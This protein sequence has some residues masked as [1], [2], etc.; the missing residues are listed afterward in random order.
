MVNCI[1]LSFYSHVS[2]LLFY[3][4]VDLRWLKIITMQLANSVS[5][6]IV[7]YWGYFPLNLH[8]KNELLV[9][10]ILLLIA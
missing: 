4:M 5:V 2:T 10:L 6:I 9:E 3:Y 1:E 7:L 8:Y